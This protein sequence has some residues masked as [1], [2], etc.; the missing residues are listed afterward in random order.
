MRTAAGKE[1]PLNLKDNSA[2]FDIK[3]LYE[4]GVYSFKIEGRIKKA[5]YVYTVVDALR[6]N[7]QAFLTQQKNRADNSALYKVFNRDF[8]NTFL[9]G[10]INKEMFIDN[11]RD[12]T[13][14]HLSNSMPLATPEQL[15]KAHLALYAEKE[16][17][18]RSVEEEIKKLHIDK[19]ALNIQLTGKCGEPLNVSVKSV[20][21]SFNVLSETPLVRNGNEALNRE[22]VLKRFKSINETAYYIEKLKMNHLDTDLF[23]PFK[24]L[25]SLKKR[26]L[27]ILNGSKE[28]TTPIRLPQL[29]KQ[30]A[31]TGATTLS[32]L[33]SSKDDLPLLDEHSGDIY[34]QLPSSF[35]NNLDEYI[36]IFRDNRKLIPWFP[37]VIIDENYNVAVTLLSAL[38]PPR[39]VS[40]NTGVGYEASKRGIDWIAGPQMNI[41]NSYSLLSLKENLNC[42]GAFLSNELS[43]NQIR[44]ITCP[45]DFE[46]HFSI[47]HPTILMTS[48]QCLFHQVTGCEKNRIDATCIQNCDKKATIT[49]MKK[50]S[51]FIEK[52]RGN[53][54]NIYSARNYLNTAIVKD[55]P[56]TFSRFLIDLRNIE[57]ETR[58]NVDKAELIH[59]FETYIKEN[60]E[61]SA[62]TDTRIMYRNDP[63]LFES[64]KVLHELIQKTTSVQYKRGIY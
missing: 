39:I 26:L 37:S 22:M 38:H 32:I 56:H 30:K 23:I 15:E 45:K 41:S 49:T 29:K 61:R 1:Y 57:T 5:D 35:H 12:H 42:K 54:H 33:I 3:E 19:I 63:T 55:M 60:S 62:Q 6:K 21:H 64:E 27:F 18:K 7:I 34:F 11:P 10:D 40:N 52:S 8:S 16:A 24:E 48:R 50:E 51:F 25:T 2:F 28:S 17:M 59:Y 46:L 4:A 44:H 43:R 58:I 36:N 13:I 31:V 47:Y 53:Y 9:K 14:Q 20:D